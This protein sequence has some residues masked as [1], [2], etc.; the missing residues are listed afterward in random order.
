MVGFVNV[1]PTD[2]VPIWKQI[3][4][5]VRRMAVSGS[6]PA[7]KAVPSVR[8]LA[9]ELRVN[10]ATV[11]KAYNRLTEAG[12]LIVRRGEGTFFAERTEKDIRQD[13]RKILSEGALRFAEVAT[14]VQAERAEASKE[15]TRAFDAVE[16]N[17]DGGER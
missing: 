1:D 10:P 17:L 15:L 16:A 6:S 9:R 7:G 11:A 3:E 8:E 12:V 4:D 5:G 2:A 13:R 14:S